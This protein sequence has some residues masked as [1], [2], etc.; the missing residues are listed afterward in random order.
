MNG[1]NTSGGETRTS[2]ARGGKSDYMRSLVERLDSTRAS[3]FYS[4]LEEQIPSG[5]CSELITRLGCFYPAAAEARVDHPVVSQ[6]SDIG[7]G[8][9]VGVPGIARSNHV[10]RSASDY[11]TILGIDDDRASTHSRG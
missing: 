3:G 6:A 10:N 9:V 11:R 8:L 7:A 4:S 5:S 1:R 2:N